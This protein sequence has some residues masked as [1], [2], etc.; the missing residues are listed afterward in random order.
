VGNYLVFLSKG[1]RKT[2][3]A[4]PDVFTYPFQSLFRIQARQFIFQFVKQ[5][6]H[7][8]AFKCEF[9]R[10]PYRNRLKWQD[11]RLAVSIVNSCSNSMFS[12]YEG[13]QN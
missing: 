13:V 2:Y 11:I 10:Y 6:F 8:R 4:F 12:G 1:R 7:N 9:I 3:G 5:G